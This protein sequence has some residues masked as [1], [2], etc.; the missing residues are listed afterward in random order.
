[1]NTNQKG[2]FLLVAVALVA[3]AAMVGF[4]VRADDDDDLTR[5]S[6]RLTGFQE[7][8][9][10]LVNATGTFR[11]TLS[12][13][14][15]RISWTLTYTGLTGGAQAAHIH[16]AP[17]GVTGG[18][19]V[20]FCNNAAGGTVNNGAAAPKCPDDGT[21]AHSGTVTGFW[22]A[23]DVQALAS[24]NVAAGNF[25]GLLRFLRAGLGYANVHTMAHPGGEIRGQVRVH[26]RER[27]EEN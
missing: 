23:A 9:P 21:T 15:T 12:E 27:G 18:I 2:K 5:F 17:R 10:Q 25:A 6:T 8:A 20:F 16:F 26:E 14:G 11:G 3:M 22:T 19:V 24:Q 1:M 7:V 4:A 13:D